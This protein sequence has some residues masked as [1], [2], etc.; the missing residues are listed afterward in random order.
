MRI[1]I[2]GASGFLGTALTRALRAEGHERSA[3]VRRPPAAG[4]VPWDPARPLDPGQLFGYHAVVH[5]AA[6]NIAGR[7]NEKFKRELLESRVQGTST[8][9]TAAAE[10]YRRTGQP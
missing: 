9:A 2:S 7:W 8:L 3:L 10:S 1:L 5:L 6:K 4:E